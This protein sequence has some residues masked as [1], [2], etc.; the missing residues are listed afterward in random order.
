MVQLSTALTWT[1]QSVYTPHDR[2]AG[3]T[4]TDSEF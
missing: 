2:T 4:S 3:D 1:L